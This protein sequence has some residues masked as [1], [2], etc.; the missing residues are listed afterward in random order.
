MSGNDMNWRKKS[1]RIRPDGRFVFESM[2]FGKHTFT[3]T[4]S[5]GTEKASIE[6]RLKRDNDITGVQIEKKDGEYTVYAGKHVRAIE[7]Y[8]DTE[9][10]E[11]NLRRTNWAAIDTDQNVYTPDGT[12]PP[13]DDGTNITPGGLEVDEHKKLDFKSLKG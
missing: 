13:A 2:P 5:D 9:R 7:L 11:L 1:D 12:I 10:G 6:W 8:F 4:D 3:V